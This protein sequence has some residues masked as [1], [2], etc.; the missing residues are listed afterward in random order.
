VPGEGTLYWS[1][2]KGRSRGPAQSG[3]SASTSAAQPSATW[4]YLPGQGSTGLGYTMFVGALLVACA[5]ANRDGSRQWFFL[6]TAVLCSG[7]GLTLWRESRVAVTRVE[8]LDADEGLRLI[9]PTASRLLAVSPLVRVD[10]ETSRLAELFG[11]KELSLRNA[12]EVVRIRRPAD[13]P[14]FIWRVRECQP[15][16]Q[17][18]IGDQRRPWVVTATVVLLLCSASLTI[19][20]T[21]GARA[22][23]EIV[24]VGCDRR[25]HRGDR[26]SGRTEIVGIESRSLGSSGNA[27]GALVASRAH[28][29]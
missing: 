24:G 17:C 4:V 16:L 18:Q 1:H 8:V 9:S 23:T 25:R 13:T 14:E 3:P 7:L 2:L 19:V 5:L 15:A 28:G 11:W 27:G 21:L 10:G 12:S 29:V 20:G 22:R 6:A 26:C